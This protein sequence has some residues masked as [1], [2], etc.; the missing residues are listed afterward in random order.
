[1]ENLLSALFES[2]LNP[3]DCVK[4]L[5]L[6]RVGLLVFYL[7]IFLISVYLTGSLNLFLNLK[8]NEEGMVIS[9]L[10]GFIALMIGIKLM[11]GVVLKYSKIK[12]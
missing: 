11:L 12:R 2:P 6:L 7:G 10:F 9:R 8:Q 1:L 4:E 3:P 5:W